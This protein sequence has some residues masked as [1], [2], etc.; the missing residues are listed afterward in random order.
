[1]QTIARSLSLDQE[2]EQREDERCRGH[3]CGI[4]LFVS[5]TSSLC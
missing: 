4:L 1:M 5:D 2:E 3:Q